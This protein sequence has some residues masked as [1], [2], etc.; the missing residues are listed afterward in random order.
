MVFRQPG[1]N[2]A[3]INSKKTQRD[4]FYLYFQLFFLINRTV[5]PTERKL[6]L[7]KDS[8]AKTSY[9]RLPALLRATK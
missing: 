7:F 4:E 9:V 5:F 8:T 2:Q 1:Y 3:N 6:V